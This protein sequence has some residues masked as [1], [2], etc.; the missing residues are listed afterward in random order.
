M[1]CILAYSLK[2]FV[3]KII[4]LNKTEIFSTKH[5]Y[6]TKRPVRELKDIKIEIDYI[7]GIQSYYGEIK[8]TC[9][10]MKIIRTNCLY[11]L[12][13]DTFIFKGKPVILFER[14]V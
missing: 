3:K 10:I 9:Y 5:F 13:K 6:S 4:Q 7:Q 14:I 11:S 1:V 8:K 2:R 12:I